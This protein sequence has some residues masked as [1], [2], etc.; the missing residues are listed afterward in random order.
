M[1]YYCEICDTT[2][3]LKW[4]NN[5]PKSP[6]HNQYEKSIGI[7]HTIKNPIFFDIDRIL[8]DYI[9]NHNKKIYFFNCEFKLSFYNLTPHNKSDFYQKTRTTDLKK[10]L[11]YWIECFS[12]RGNKLSHIIEMNVKSICDKI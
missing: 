9:N 10:N 2:N 7:N 5:R 6:T 12:E 8:N 1:D 3:K 4:K 11:L